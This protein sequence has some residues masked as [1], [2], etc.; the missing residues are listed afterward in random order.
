MVSLLAASL[1]AAHAHAQVTPPT[2]PSST[3]TSSAPT[4]PAPNPT[5][6]PTP[7][8]IHDLA[9]QQIKQQEHQRILGIAPNFNT[10]YIKNAAPLTP[11][12][13]FKLAFRGAVDPFQFAAAALIAGYSQADGQDEAYGQ[14]VEG[15]SKR[16]GANYADSFDG[17]ILGNAIFPILFREDPR[18]FRMGSGRFVKR[19]FYALSTAVIT[20]NDNGSWGP[21]FANVAG[22]LAA[23]GI[24]NLYYP[25]ADRGVELTFQGAATVTIEGAIGTVFIEFWPDISHKLFK[26]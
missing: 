6:A 22:N 12:Q 20:K 10:S 18:Y 17:V 8:S 7:L 14:G 26:K 4:P 16:F 25:A 2:T 3:S 11:K 24:S 5:P 13:K 1:F 19:F 23:G 15:F 9:E 21:N